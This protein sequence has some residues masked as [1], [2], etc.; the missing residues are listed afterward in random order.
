MKFLPLIWAT[1]WRRKARTAF[2]LGAIVVAFVLYGLL[3][4]VEHAFTH[5]Q[6]LSGAE[7]LLTM[8]RDSVMQP[9][10]QAAMDRVRALPGAREVTPMTWF[11]GTWGPARETVA[12]V[13]VDPATYFS[14]YRETVAVAP[15]ALRAFNGQRNAVLVGADVAKKRGWKPGDRLS[16]H[17]TLWPQ[18]DGSMDWSFEIVGLV[19]PVDPATRASHGGRVLM[20]FDYFDEARLYGKGTIGWFVTAVKDPALADRMAGQIDA[21]FV[22]SAQPT[23]TRTAQEFALIFM[24]QM[25]DVTTI[26]RVVLGAVFFTLLL[27]IANTMMQ[28]VRERMGEIAVLRTLGFS[29]ARVVGFVTVEGLLLCLLG[30]A[31]GLGLSWLL[32]PV[33]KASLQGVNLSAGAMLPGLAVAVLLALATSLPPAVREVR[34]KLGDALTQPT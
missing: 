1:L 22:N 9:L 23:E 15:E 21:L 4:V 28:A 31:A 20:R 30:A 12:A 3:V 16:L 14:V 13:P 7:K 27:L 32:L 34:R 19:D 8:N 33:V 25:A 18:A 29:D 26:I 24:R 2:T 11:G 10:P 6:G 17:S 5:P